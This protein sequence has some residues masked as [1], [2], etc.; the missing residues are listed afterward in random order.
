MRVISLS[1]SDG[2]IVNQKH[3]CRGQMQFQLRRSVIEFAGCVYFQTRMAFVIRV[4]ETVVQ[5][6]RRADCDAFPSQSDLR[7]L[8]LIGGE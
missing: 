8:F 4:L 1:I 5:F 7:T 3:W 6:S 2:H